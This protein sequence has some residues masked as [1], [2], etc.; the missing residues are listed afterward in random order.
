MHKKGNV[1]AYSFCQIDSKFNE[2]MYKIWEIFVNF[3]RSWLA[4]L[5]FFLVSLQFHL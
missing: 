3:L 4:K 1:N 5:S 2:S